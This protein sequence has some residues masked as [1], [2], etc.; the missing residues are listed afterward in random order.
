MQDSEKK[1]TLDDLFVEIFTTLKLHTDTLRILAE[2]VKKLESVYK[3]EEK[4]E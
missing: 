3:K 1:Q 2:R 4:S